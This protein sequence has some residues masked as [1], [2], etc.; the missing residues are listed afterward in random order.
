MED[1]S[2]TGTLVRGIGDEVFIFLAVII[3]GVMSCYVAVRMLLGEAASMNQ[4]LHPDLVP[5]VQSTRRDMGVAHEESVVPEAENCPVCLGIV[6][7]SVQ[8]NCGH[9]FCAQ[10]VLEYWRHDQ[11]PRPTR[12]PVCRRTVSTIIT[13]CVVN[14]DY[15][16][17]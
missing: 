2:G 15:N 1:I 3:V 17:R 12:C 5:A 16:Y 14:Y 4:N 8:T 13:S 10:C 6:E 11:W 7:N 9:R